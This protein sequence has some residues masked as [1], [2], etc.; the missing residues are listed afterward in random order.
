MNSKMFRVGYN[1]GRDDFNHKLR[2]RANDTGYSG[3]FRPGYRRGWADA[4]RGEDN[5][6]EAWIGAH[7]SDDMG[8]LNEWQLR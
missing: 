2:S 7:D 6:I 8:E 1:A 3:S 5:V 4:K